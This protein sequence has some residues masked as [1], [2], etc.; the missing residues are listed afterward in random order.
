[1][2]IPI[3]IDENLE[4]N[5]HGSNYHI[6]KVEVFTGNDRGEETDSIEI[7]PMLS[8]PNKLEILHKFIGRPRDIGYRVRGEPSVRLFLRSEETH[9]LLTLTIC[10]HKGRQMLS[11]KEEK[12][13]V[14]YEAL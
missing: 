9:K 4:I 6:E 13:M 10:H 11:V 5:G 8:V 3:S 7:R 1:M 2:E 14:A 12:E